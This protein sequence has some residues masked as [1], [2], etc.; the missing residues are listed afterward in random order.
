MNGHGSTGAGTG[1]ADGRDA[2]GLDADGRDADGLHADGRDAGSV[3]ADGRDADGW[4]ADGWAALA[5]AAAGLL[6]RYG[7]LAVS[8]PWGA[9]KT[10]LLEGLDVPPDWRRLRIHTQEGDQDVPYGALAQ[11]LDLGGVLGA[12]PPRR[13]AGPQALAAEASGGASRDGGPPAVRTPEAVVDTGA[14]ACGALAAGGAPGGSADRGAPVPDAAAGGAGP[15]YP[16]A[17]VGADQQP[18]TAAPGRGPGR[19]RPGAAVPAQDPYPAALGAQHHPRTAAAVPAQDPYAGAG[20]P[21]S[22]VGG[23]AV[24]LRLRLALAEFLGGGSPVLLLVDGAQWVDAASAAAI[25]HCARTLPPGRLAVVAAE[26]TAAH[27]GYAAR[28]LGGHPPLLPV[29]PADRLETAAALQRAGLP[30]RWAAPVH[31]YCGGN[32]ALLA[33]GCRALAASRDLPDSFGD[34]AGAPYALPGRRQVRDLAA[35]WLVSVPVEVRASLQTAALA[36]HPDADLLRRAGCPHAEDH[37]EHAVRCGLL[38]PDEAYG[39]QSAAPPR[40]RF[41]ADALAEAAAA[42]ATAPERRRIHAALAGAVHDP[43]QRARHRALAQETADQATAED[44]AQAAALARGAGERL[45]AAELMM[46]AAR[47]TP[48]D[49]PALRLDRLC[50]AARDA[51]AAGSADLAQEAASR[52]AEDRGSPAQQVNALLAV[53][54]ARGQDLAETG[55]LLAAARRAACQDP[56]LLAAVELRTAVQANVAAGD[57]ALALHHADAATALARQC[58]DTPLEAAALTMA[59]RME[60]VLGRVDSAP[61]TLAAALALAV[62]PPRIGIR[63]SPEYL[64]ARHAVFDG[65]LAQ[66]RRALTDLLPDAQASGEAEDLVDLWRSLAEVDCGLGACSRALR[67]AALAVDLTASAGLSPGPAWYTAA[68]AHSHGGSFPQALRYAA[69]GLRASREEHDA[70]HTTR[71]LWILGAVHLH[72]GQVE[73][74]ATALAEVDALEAYGG[75]VDPA[76]LRWQAD[77]VEAFAASGRTA[78]AYDLLDRMQDAVGPHPGHAALRAALTRSRAACLHLAGE[79]DEAVELLEDAARTFTVL[80]RPVE[81]GRTRLARGRVERRRRR[82]AAART[83]WEAARTV[84]AEAGARPWTLLAEDHLSHLAGRSPA[85]AAPGAARPAPA[86]TEH[87]RRLAALVCAGA[88]NQEAAQQ[89]FV[90]AKTV[91]AT[92]SRIYRKLGIRNRTQ[93]TATLSP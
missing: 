38:T 81:A 92:L 51:A 14:G 84:F 78:R 10:T 53:A 83:A 39:P 28:L 34:S 4:D 31:R 17:A 44:T 18:G 22:G 60:R 73:Q 63:N 82:A 80:G 93:L 76:V 41:A 71:C 20:G 16:D 30:A 91:E 52:I 46:L 2:G 54:D 35:H 66:A 42:T 89:M 74:A 64:A 90:S 23:G 27:P 1:S 48:A 9:G 37:L 59:A 43:V 86:L 8:G 7:R 67:W 58:G 11:V 61:A 47:L 13:T 77:A 87:E 32:R 3:D 6:E 21:G 55:A 25:G 65:R 56:A 40:T 68:L 62:P 75:A 24:A 88:T 50:G 12:C 5:A 45:L 49:R 36:R 26:R 19:A 57:A 69:Q 33:A 15:R 29:P 72:H 79:H 70:L 85:P